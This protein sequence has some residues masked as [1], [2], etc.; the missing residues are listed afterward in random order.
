MRQ[1]NLVFLVATLLLLASLPSFAQSWAGKGR[2]QG[3]I[4]DESDK[5]IEGAK[6]WLRMDATKPI[7][8]QNPGDGPGVI[9]TSKY[10]KWSV[11]G[12]AQGEWRVLILKD[13]YL[14]SE[15][16]IKV[17][18]GGAPPPPII[19]KLK[20]AQQQAAATPQKQNPALEHI[21]KG[22]DLLTANKY[23]EA[24][25]E[26]EQALT[27]L[28]PENHPAILR[29]IARTYWQEKNGEQAVAT[30]KKAL[31]IKPDDVES[32]R[33]LVNLLVATGHE[34]EA[35]EYMAKLPQG[36]TVDPA[37]LLNIGIK[38]YNDKK[39]PEAL[40]EFD[41]VVKENPQL[42]DAYYYRGLTY[43]ALN[44]TPEAKADFQKVIDLDPNGANAKEAREFLKGL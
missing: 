25:A 19:I 1:R 36:E 11:L 39:L 4:R 12:L 28:E 42:A 43:L 8:P 6:I 13:G 41:R 34:A 23:P 27:T 21:Q 44:K 26:Y 37:T 10:G 32:L 5:P 40:Q 29:G 33:L 22:N 20:V 15:G 17:L 14:P 9:T 35:K 3:E 7:D 30:L 2:L 24:R 16:T 38:L 18:E 31:E